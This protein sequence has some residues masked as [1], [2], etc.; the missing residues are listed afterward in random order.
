MRFSRNDGLSEV[1]AVG[2]VGPDQVI[3]QYAKGL[4]GDSRVVGYYTCD[5]CTSEGSATDIPP[6][7]PDQGE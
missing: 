1:G 7:Q 5:E 4:A 2:N 3:S 6:V